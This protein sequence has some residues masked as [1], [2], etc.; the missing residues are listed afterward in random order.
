DRKLAFT[1]GWSN[2]PQLWKVPEAEK[3]GD[4]LKHA[5]KVW[6]AAL[7]PDGSS[8]AT[9]GSDRRVRVWNVQ[10]RTPEPPPL[11][12]PSEVRSLAYSPDG[13][14]IATGDTDTLRIWD[15]TTRRELLSVPRHGIIRRLA[16]SGDG[17]QLA[18]V[19]GDNNVRL[20]KLPVRPRVSMVHPLAHLPEG[21]E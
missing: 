16:F 21:A 10:T 14:L 8:A 1:L 19:H 20:W 12:H 11:E 17:R 9:A 5:E 4:Y 13:K 15:L 3:Y 7:S 2:E 18:S 6:D